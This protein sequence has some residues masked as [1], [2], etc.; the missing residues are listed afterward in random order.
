MINTKK[1]MNHRFNWLN[2]EYSIS[3]HINIRK[4]L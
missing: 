2:S 1:E 4:K 3:K